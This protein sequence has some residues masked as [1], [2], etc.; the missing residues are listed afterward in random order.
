MAAFASDPLALSQMGCLY[1]WSHQVRS[2]HTKL[3]LNERDH[4]RDRTFLSFSTVDTKDIMKKVST[5]YTSFWPDLGSLGDIRTPG[6]GSRKISTYAKHFLRDPESDFSPIPS[7]LH[8]NKKNAVKRYARFRL[9]SHYLGVETGRHP[10]H[11]LDWAD[12]KCS[13]CSKST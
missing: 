8:N 9:G 7:Y 6:L 11:Y 3:L 2:A 10:P 5:E 13:R 12:R 4:S 1:T